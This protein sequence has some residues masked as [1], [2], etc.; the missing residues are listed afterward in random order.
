MKRSS[1]VLAAFAL[2]CLLPGCETYTLVEASAP[3]KMAD[4]YSVQPQI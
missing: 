3:V 2:L 1:P 4:T